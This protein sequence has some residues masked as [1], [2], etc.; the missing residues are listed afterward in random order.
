[1]GPW[2]GWSECDSECGP[3]KQTRVRDC[4]C[5][6]EEC[7]GPVQEDRECPEEEQ[8]PCE[9]ES[10]CGWTPWCNWSD[11]DTSDCPGKQVRTRVCDCEKS[12]CDE[13][14]KAKDCPGEPIEEK[15]CDEVE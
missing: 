4:G 1:M 14:T 12:D 8:T 2:C 11:C 5:P 10:E 7:E 15:P 9:K 3:G 6:P 13:S